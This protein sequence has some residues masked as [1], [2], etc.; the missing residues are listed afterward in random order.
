MAY[1]RSWRPNVPTKVTIQWSVASVAYTI[2]FHDTYHWDEMMVIKSAIQQFPY[3]EQMYDPD[4]KIWYLI[5]KHINGIKIM[6]EL[7]PNI[8]ELTFIEKPIQDF[9][10]K[11]V[12]VDTYIKSFE[13]L[14]GANIKDFK[15]EEYNLAK[16]LYRRVCMENHPDRGGNSNTM[17]EINEC[18]SNI[19]KLYFNQKKELEYA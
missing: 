19:E 5:E 17:S 14:T 2:K 16:K 4:N 3:G 10:G 12:S 15:P 11:F 1:K 9:Q 6:L 13:R 7:M 8:F 18:W